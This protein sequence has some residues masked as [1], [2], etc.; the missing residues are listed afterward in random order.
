MKEQGTLRAIICVVTV[1]DAIF[2]IKAKTVWT[3]IE[4]TDVLKS[5][6]CEIHEDVFFIH[7]SFHG[8]ISFFHILAIVNNAV[9]NIRVHTSF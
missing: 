3:T 9:I 7:S 5:Q 1:I 8:H 4:V 2:S 6:R